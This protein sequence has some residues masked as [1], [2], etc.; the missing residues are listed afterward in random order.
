MRRY[1]VTSFSTGE[2]SREFSGR[3]DL[4]QYRTGCKIMENMFPQQ[5]GGAEKRP[6]TMYADTAAGKCI[7]IPWIK[8]ETEFLVL[9]LS[10]AKIRYYAYSETTKKLS[11]VVSGGSPVETDLSG[12]SWITEAKLEDVKYVQDSVSSVYDTMYFSCPGYT[13]RKLV[14]TSD[15]SWAFSAATLTAYAGTNANACELFEDRLILSENQTLYGSKTASHLDFGVS[16]PVV[17]TDGFSFKVSA[18][19]LTTIKWLAASTSL[20]FGTASAIYHVAGKN[21]SLDGTTLAIW[22]QVQA[23]IGCNSVQPVMFNNFLIFVQKDSKKIH[24]I[25]YSADTEKYETSDLTFFADHITGTGIKQLFFQKNPEPILWGITE[26][27]GLVSMVYSPVTQTVGWSRHDLSG[28]V[29]AGCVIQTS[30]EDIVCL[31]VLRG[32]DRLICSMVP[33]YYADITDAHFV[34]FGIYINAGSEI[35]VT[36]VTASQYV[37]GA[38]GQAGGH[39]FHIDGDTVYEA[40][41]VSTEWT[42][43]QYSATNEQI[44]TSPAAPW[45]N[46]IGDGADNTTALVTWLDAQGQTGKAAQLCAALSE[47][48]Y[49]DWFM[50]SKKELEK[51]HENLFDSDIGDFTATW[52]WSSSESSEYFS[53]GGGTI[54]YGTAQAIFMSNGG[55]GKLDMNSTTPRL[56]AVRSYTQTTRAPVVTAASHGLAADQKIIFSNVEGDNDLNGNTYT[57]KNEDTNTFE[58][59]TA[60]GTQPAT[61]LKPGTGGTITLV[62]GDTISNLDHLEGEEV[63]VVADG[64]VMPSKTVASGDI[65]EIEYARKFHVGLPFTA[66]LQTN[67]LSSSVAKDIKKLYIK[68]M[69]SV[70]FYFG[71][72][73]DHLTP[74]VL[75]DAP[76][77]MGE[78]PE[79]ISDD[80][81][82]YFDSDNLFSPSCMIVSGDPL[83]LTILCLIAEV[84][85]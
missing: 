2:M 4:P 80:I 70:I 32:D 37:L 44:N 63:Q 17:A 41:P 83:P 14:R 42:G 6:G 27:G 76:P 77:V 25:Q 13:V 79:L 15:T 5:T 34:D 28:T 60:D 50:P 22:P 38:D 3:L 24:M 53:Y 74:I 9:E 67:S 45:G 12:A 1:D 52:Y 31:S 64:Y 19:E 61:V 69:D 40:A 56:R 85:E 81:K 59:Y 73:E 48:G 54:V 29:E 51:I 55:T 68:F 26:D 46:E 84:E 16:S 62:Q 58:L 47:G 72:D 57:V 75:Q 66:K 20:L 10:A 33:R 8:S 36:S 43:K 7:L 35:D 39:V 23:G 82:A 49:S 71:P 78:A 11:L 18:K 30:T 65:T 21:D